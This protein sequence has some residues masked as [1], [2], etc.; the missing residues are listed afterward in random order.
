MSGLVVTSIV[1]NPRRESRTHSVARTLADAV[2]AVLGTT[3]GPEIDLAALGPRLFDQADPDAND[4]VEQTLGAD[5]LIVASPTFKATY[6]G[7]LKLFLERIAADALAGSV[8]VPVLLGGA[9]DHRL[10]VDVHL[11]PLLFELGAALPTRGLFVLES[12]LPDFP[13]TAAQWASRHAAA[14]VRQRA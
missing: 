14:L 8:A 1:G 7:L 5:L 12:E 10:A 13:A 9:P 11:A 2:S 3:P 6:S 4:A